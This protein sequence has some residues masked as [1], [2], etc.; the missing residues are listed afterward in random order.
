MENEDAEWGVIHPAPGLPP[1][2]PQK[3]PSSVFCFRHRVCLEGQ[4]GLAQRLQ[5]HLGLI[6]ECIASG[7]HS[8]GL[9]INQLV[10]FL[11]N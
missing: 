5:M 7:L 1:P 11:I 8:S 10:S 3:H 6:V 9:L 2:P 4:P